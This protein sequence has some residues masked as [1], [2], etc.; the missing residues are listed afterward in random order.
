MVSI[1][2]LQVADIKADTVSIKHT[3]YY[4][5]MQMQLDKVFMNPRLS[6]RRVIYIEVM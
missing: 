6:A 3:Y 1:G 5:E 2:S 4:Q